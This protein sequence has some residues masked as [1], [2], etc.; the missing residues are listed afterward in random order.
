VVEHDRNGNFAVE[1][2]LEKGS[3]IRIQVPR[4]AW[5]DSPD[6]IIADTKQL[7]QDCKHV[8]GVGGIGRDVKE[9]E[10]EGRMAYL[11]SENDAPKRCVWWVIKKIEVWR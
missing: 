9:G 1:A 8:G 7:V 11:E 4:A 2:P 5:P 3:A 6:L 10:D